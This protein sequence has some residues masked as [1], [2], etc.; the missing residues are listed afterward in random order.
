MPEQLRVGVIGA[1]WYSDLRHLPAL[2]SHPRAQ[3][4]AI[5]DID[6]DR[7]EAM[8]TKYDIP[9]VSRDYRVVID[10]ANL[11]ALLVVTPDAT[12]PRRKRWTMIWTLH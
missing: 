7:A 12:H 11:D 9:L 5:C 3:T 8:A 4:V 10:R 6:H 1:S 2:K